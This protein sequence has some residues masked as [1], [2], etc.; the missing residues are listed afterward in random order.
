MEKIKR[1]IQKKDFKLYN[2]PNDFGEEAEITIK[3][4]RKT[5]SKL[6]DESYELAKIQETSGMMQMLNEPEEDVWND[7]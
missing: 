2:I 1:I 6:I 3:P 7:L 4:M 5:H